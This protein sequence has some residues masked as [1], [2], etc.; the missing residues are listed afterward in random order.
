MKLGKCIDLTVLTPNIV[1]GG[2]ATATWAAT[3]ASH[4]TCEIHFPPGRY[5]PG[6]DPGSEIDAY[7][8]CTLR[9][10]GCGTVHVTAAGT[11][12][13]AE[14]IP[15]AF[16]QLLLRGGAGVSAQ[17]AILLFG[18]GGGVACESTGLTGDDD[19]TFKVVCGMELTLEFDGTGATTAPSC[20]VLFD[21]KIEA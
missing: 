1:Q 3:S 9:F 8:S 7:A 5:C 21:V 20:D 12:G 15:Y 6:G 11:T 19:V 16:S 10:T 17:P 4:G 13:A 18:E 2:G 14:G